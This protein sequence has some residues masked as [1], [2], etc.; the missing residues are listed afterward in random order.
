[1]LLQLADRTVKMPTGILDDV[2]VQVGK[3]VFPAN[4]VIIDCQVDEEIPIISG[5]TFLSTRRALIDCETGE[6]KMRVGRVG[7]GSRRSR[8]LEKG[9]LVRATT[10]RRKINNTCEAINRGATTPGPETA[11]SLPRVEQLQQVLQ[12]CKTTIG[13]TV[14][15]IKGYQ[16]GL[17][18]EQDSLGRGAQAFQGT[19]NKAEPE[20]ER[21]GKGSD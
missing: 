18:H 13:L 20:Y 9:I 6:L 17:L 4:F 8:V 11:S 15:D 14:V 10:L 3:F 5:R 19:S 1:M 7:Y 16:P 21:S 2:L 12:E